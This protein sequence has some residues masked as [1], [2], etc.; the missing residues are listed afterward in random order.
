M[1]NNK[2]L[3]A[4]SYF[5]VLFA[6]FLVPIIIFFVT[7]DEEVKY[8]A[9]KSLISHIIPLILMVIL[10][11]SIIVTVVPFSYSMSITYEEPSFWMTSG[12]I[13]LILLYIIVYMIVLI[14]NIVQGIKVLR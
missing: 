2:V 3:S 8:H 1:D 13:L 10:F 7:R 5:S 4:L 11:I 9:K 6:P 14:W 12:P